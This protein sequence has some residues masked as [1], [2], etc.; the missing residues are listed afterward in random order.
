MLNASEARALT[1]KNHDYY[2][3]SVASFAKEYIES[4]IWKDILVAI[5]AGSFT[6]KHKC[7]ETLTIDEKHM[8]RKVLAMDYGYV[9][10]WHDT[11]IDTIVIDWGEE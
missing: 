8:I 1:Q 4:T 6:T 7:A 3:E 11:L 9:N 5:D 10:S 2:W